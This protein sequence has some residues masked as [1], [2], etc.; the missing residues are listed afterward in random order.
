MLLEY[1]KELIL[2]TA[3]EYGFKF[4]GKEEENPYAYNEDLIAQFDRDIILIKH[5][6][7]SRMEE[8]QECRR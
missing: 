6:I 3:E 8:K 2:T 4:D 1:H 5:E 7:R